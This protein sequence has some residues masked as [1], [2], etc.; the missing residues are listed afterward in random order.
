[1]SHSNFICLKRS[2]IWD[3]PVQVTDCLA[4]IL[5]QS[6][7]KSRKVGSSLS[8]TDP[9]PLILFPLFTADFI[10]IGA[11]RYRHW[12]GCVWDLFC[13]ITGRGSQ[14]MDSRKWNGLV[15]YNAFVLVSNSIKIIESTRHSYHK[16]SVTGALRPVQHARDN[17]LCIQR[18]VELHLGSL[19]SLLET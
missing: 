10:L 1:M 15:D 17:S 2:E 14:I 13:Y 5:F 8:R 7:I 11:G 6:L 4:W 16:G 19:C 9:V 3:R 18:D 12:S